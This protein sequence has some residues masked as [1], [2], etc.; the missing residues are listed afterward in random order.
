MALRD[1]IDI[2]RTFAE[3]L[4]P[5]KI[6]EFLACATPLDDPCQGDGPRTA[7]LHVHFSEDEPQVEALATHL[8]EQCMYYALP[9]KRRLEFQRAIAQDFSITA[10]V[11]Q[12]V[13][14]AFI[15]FNAEYPSRASEV[16]EVLAYCVT[17]H[18]LSAAQVAA[19][20]ALK[21]SSN[22]PVHGLDGIHAVFTSEALTIYF[23]ESKL[24]ATAN[25]G[26][27]DYA[28]SASAFLADRKQYLREYQLVSDLGHFDSLEGP[29]REAALDYFD[30]LGKPTLPRRERFVGL[31]CYSEKKHYANVLP[32]DDGPPGKHETH[33]ARLYAG[34][35]THHQSA[36]KKHLEAQGGD[37]R[38]A[39]LFFVAVPDVNEF[40][41]AFYRAMGVPIPD[42]LP[43]IVE[44]QDQDT[45]RK[46]A[47]SEAELSVKE[48][49]E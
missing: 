39:I 21:T 45:E 47:D 14:E 46:I 11:H 6:D 48:A 44:F 40:R 26:A 43:D 5:S 1:S 16:G 27:K 34:E 17:Q 25:S 22:M 32:I 20:M 49:G 8:W 3:L 37:P 15:A 18:Y 13:R 19:K 36:A 10:R 9:R 35:H 31:I 33:F 30:I 4:N 38:K 42:G 24:S 12:A 41:K 28:Q 2:A 23:L 29:A 7:L